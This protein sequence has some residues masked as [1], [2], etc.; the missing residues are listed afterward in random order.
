MKYWNF[1]GS[2]LFERSCLFLH[3]VTEKERLPQKSTS[4]TTMREDKIMFTDVVSDDHIDCPAIYRL[5]RDP[6]NSDTIPEVREK[7][8]HNV[9]D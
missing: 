4:N 2:S 3:I 9:G 6:G 8:A 7:G 1:D 5:R